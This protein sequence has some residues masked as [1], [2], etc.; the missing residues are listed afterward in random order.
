MPIAG[1]VA[2]AVR[3]EC[4]RGFHREGEHIYAQPARGW[5][6]RRRTLS[7]A[8]LSG[9]LV[10][11]GGALSAAAAHRARTRLRGGPWRRAT[12]AALGRRRRSGERGGGARRVAGALRLRRARGQHL[13]AVRHVRHARRRAGGGRRARVRQRASGRGTARRG[14]QGG[15]ARG[16]RGAPAHSGAAD[17]ERVVGRQEVALALAWGAPLAAVDV[18]LLS[19]QCGARFSG[20]ARARVCALEQCALPHARRSAQAAGES[21]GGGEFGRHR[22]VGLAACGQPRGRGSG[23]GDARRRRRVGRI[24]AAHGG[25]L[26]IRSGPRLSGCEHMPEVC[27]ACC[28]DDARARASQAEDRAAVRQMRFLGTAGI[29]GCG[30]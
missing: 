14:R 25:Q 15:G 12:A 21:E 16:G 29:S 5:R 6:G 18:R 11:R 19:R 27:G 28:R 13:C 17:S 23:G 1:G 4:V 24:Q 22:R 30:L 8:S 3:A 20:A 2:V 26:A 7:R 9:H 10:A